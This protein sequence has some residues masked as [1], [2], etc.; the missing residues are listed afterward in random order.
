MWAIASIP[1][2]IVGFGCFVTGLVGF[3]AT[4]R[5]HDKLSDEDFKRALIGIMML[6]GF[7]GAIF[8]LAAK[9]CS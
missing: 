9:I 3:V 1:F 6:M 8:L 4:F 7:S 5:D 2:W